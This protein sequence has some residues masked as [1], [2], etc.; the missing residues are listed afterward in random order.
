MATIRDVAKRAGVSVATVSAVINKNRRVSERLTAKVLEAI[1][2]LDY[3]PNRLARALF[4]KRT[5]MIGCLVPTIANPFFPEIVKSVEDIAFQNHFGVF[6]CNT[7]VDASKV[8]YYQRML[9]ETQVDGVIMALTWELARP[10]V[11]M[12][13]LENG[14]PVVGLAGA[15]RAEQIDCVVTDDVRGGFDAT[16]H[17]IDLGHTRIGFIGAVE[18]ETTRLRLFGYRK[19]LQAAGLPVDERLIVLGSAYSEIEGYTLTKMLIGRHPEVTAIFAFNDVMALGALS[20]LN[21]SGIRVP[22]DISVIGFDDTIA[23][24]SW[25]KLSTIAVQKEE[26]GRLAANLLMGRIQGNSEPPQVFEIRPKLVVR[27]ST[28]RAKTSVL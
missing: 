16:M 25:P 22:Q 24:F 12:E 10:E 20:A 15:R 17:L 13:F 6:I 27:D 23:P 14:I 7:E 4:K 3:R 18:S 5:Y 2:E 28:G 1:K 19:A 21:D 11:I 8:A 26:M 9:I